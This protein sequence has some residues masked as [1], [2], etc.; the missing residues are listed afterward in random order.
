MKA[1]DEL[2]EVNHPGFKDEHY[3]NRRDYIA[4]VA[5]DYDLLDS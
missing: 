2:L 4:K 1:G 3:K 5:I